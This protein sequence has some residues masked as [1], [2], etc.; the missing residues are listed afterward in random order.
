MAGSCLLQS[1]N[2][3]HDCLNGRKEG[4]GSD[5]NLSSESLHIDAGQRDPQYAVK[6]RWTRRMTVSAGWSEADNKNQ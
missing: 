3:T 6:D 5:C 4:D 2:Q 1:R